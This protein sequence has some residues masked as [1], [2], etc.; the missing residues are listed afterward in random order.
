[1]SWVS[2]VVVYIMIWWMLFF[3]SLP[4]GARS[5]F[6]EGVE[7]PVGNVTSAPMVHHLKLKAMIVSALSLVVWF[8]VDW[9]IE[10][11]VV[12]FHEMSEVLMREEV[13]Q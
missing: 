2:G 9:I 7:E 3:M 5:S 8:A 1:M 10:S 6:E 12:N 4:F 13:P 11:D